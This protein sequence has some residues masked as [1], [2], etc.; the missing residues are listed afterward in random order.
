[1]GA[2]FNSLKCSDV[3]KFRL[4][5]PSIKEQNAI[6]KILSALD[7]KITLNRQMN[8]T[9]EAM[10]QAM[11]KSWFVDFDP[12]KAKVA[13]NRHGRDPKLAA[14]A[15]LSG[16]LA[17]PPG[18]PRQDQ[19]DQLPTV[20]AFDA[21]IED[22]DSLPEERRRSFAQTAVLFPDDFE[23]SELGFIPKGWSVESLSSVIQLI[24]GGTPKK[25]IPEYWGGSIPWYS[26]KDS[27]D[28]SDVFVIQTELGITETGLS[29]SS[30]RLVREG[31]IIL[32][33]RGTVG[34]MGI[35]AQEMAFN[36]SC[37]GI[38][39]QKGYSDIFVYYLVK[40]A[41]GMLQ[42]QAH[43]GVFDTITRSTFD[44]VECVVPPPELSCEMQL[45]TGVLF[46]YI[47]SNLRQS[48]I[49]AEL[50]DT[51]LPKLLLGEVTVGEAEEVL[52]NV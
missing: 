50:R 28:E 49:L 46:E 9:L 24:G 11:F 37:Y 14:M 41:L 16:K 39:P 20:E 33:A 32:S 40:E 13:A 15:A 36:Q 5:I 29:T 2:V 17:I 34:K 6:N 44:S 10:V 3:P 51:L 26:V 8:E 47:K 45:R 1:M 4:S 48:R 18:K 43:G 31:T 7:E 38:N 27:P 52:S 12:V 30:A 22:L 35:A 19:D 25:S 21:A 42:H 23:D